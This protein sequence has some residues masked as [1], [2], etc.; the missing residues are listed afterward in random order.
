MSKKTRTAFIVIRVLERE[1]KE[2]VAK[3]KKVGKNLSELVRDK[4]LK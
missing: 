4:L 3:A 1:K 2:L